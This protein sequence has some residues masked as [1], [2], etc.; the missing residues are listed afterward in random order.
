MTPAKLAEVVR[1][2][3]DSVIADSREW[4]RTYG[5]VER[6]AT[7][8]HVTIVSLASERDAMAAENARLRDQNAR[9]VALLDSEPQRDA[10]WEN[11]RRALLAEIKAGPAEGHVEDG[12]PEADELDYQEDDAR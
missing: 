9:L 6:V 3:I 12:S 7:D 1:A 5:D 8:V 10:A 2:Q 11:Q 4:L